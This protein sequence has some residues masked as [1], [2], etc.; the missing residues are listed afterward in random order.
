[1]SA[2][3]DN[4]SAIGDELAGSQDELSQRIS[5]ADA[6]RSSSDSEEE[7]LGKTPAC[8][9]DAP[10]WAQVLTNAAQSLGYQ[11]QLLKGHVKIVS[12]CTG[13]SAEGFVFKAG[14]DAFFSTVT[15]AVPVKHR[16]V[17]I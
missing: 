15:H 10:W 1:M 14:F 11:P 4:W 6:C 5:R 8:S 12:G 16:S 7:I 13:M 2:L 9:A 3:A 17:R